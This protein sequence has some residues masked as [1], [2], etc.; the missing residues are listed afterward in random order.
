MEVKNAN[1]TILNRSD[2]P[3]R[4]PASSSSTHR[5]RS[6]IESVAPTYPLD[7]FS[8]DDFSADEAEDDDDELE[9]I[10]AQEI[11]GVYSCD[12]SRR[13]SSS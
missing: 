13:M 5:R 8:T 2:L 9:P 6:P 11:Y 3:T 10:D 12:K 7:P 1:P 4:K